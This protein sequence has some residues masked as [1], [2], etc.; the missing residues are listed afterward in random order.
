[1]D[2][3]ER[4]LFIFLFILSLALVVVLQLTNWGAMQ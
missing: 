2:N 3:Y 1:M 4:G